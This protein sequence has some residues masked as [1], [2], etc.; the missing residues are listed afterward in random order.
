[1][2]DLYLDPLLSLSSS[3]DCLALR[4]RYLRAGTAREQQAW[5]NN[6][7]Q[8]ATT[9]HGIDH[10][11][12]PALI[13]QP[14]DEADIITAVKYAKAN[15]IAVS[16]KSGGHQ[17]SGACSTSGENIMID[18]N[19]TFR[20]QTKDLRVLPEKDG[21]SFVYA[22]VS[23]SLGEFNGFLGNHQLFIPHGQCIN[24]H[25]GGHTQTGT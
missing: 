19:K 20:D 15:G 2:I 6:N 5:A 24:V 10:D 4:F 12:N 9:S 18:L 17:Y 11:M 8:Y 22:S 7:Y 14:K 13:V 21:K 25:T 23:W 3:T 16:I 1:V